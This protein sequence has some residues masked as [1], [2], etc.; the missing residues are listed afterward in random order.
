VFKIDNCKIV[1]Q[2]N[3]ICA[4][5]E[6]RFYRSA[7]SCLMVNE[8]C[9]DY[10]MTNGKCTSCANSLVMVNGECVKKQVD[11]VTQTPTKTTPVQGG[12]AVVINNNNHPSSTTTTSKPNTPT[13]SVPTVQDPNCLKF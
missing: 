3:K 6:D 11:T 13:S 7:S 4:L 12:G 5:C 1:D 2:K 8:N 10:D 9:K